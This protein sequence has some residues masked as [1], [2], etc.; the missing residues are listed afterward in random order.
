MKTILETKNAQTQEVIDEV[1]ELEYSDLL[2][3]FKD[4]DFK[5]TSTIKPRSFASMQLRAK[6]ALKT[7]SQNKNEKVLLLCGSSNVDTVDIACDLVKE[8]LNTTPTIAYA[9]TKFECFGDDKVD[10]VFTSKGYVIMPC[11]HLIDHPKWLGLLNACIMQNDDLKLILCGDAIDCATLQMLWP[12]LYNV[13]HA[14][15]VLE[16]PIVDGLSIIASLIASYQIKY[17]VKPFAKEAIE[18]LCQWSTRQSG[19]KR[20]LGL[21]ELKLISLVN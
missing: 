2:S 18:L 1:F 20:Y 14:D 11:V 8:V 21:T 7:L 17:G 4:S 5:D 15:I 19:D 10:G 13:L 16:F 9:P 6:N 12:N 3:L